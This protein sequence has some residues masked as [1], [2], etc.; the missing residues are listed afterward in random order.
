[1][2]I[3]IFVWASRFGVAQVNDGHQSNAHRLLALSWAQA[4]DRAAALQAQPPTTEASPGRA[5]Q[6]PRLAPLWPSLVPSAFDPFELQVAKTGAV[7]GCAAPTPDAAQGP[8]QER[9][10]D[11]LAAES[12]SQVLVDY[13]H[14]MVVVVY[15]VHRYSLSTAWMRSTF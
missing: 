10:G 9:A 6:S 4:L 1:M 15:D 11:A 13:G 2:F 3:F 14:S 7:I 8:A 12:V 5:S